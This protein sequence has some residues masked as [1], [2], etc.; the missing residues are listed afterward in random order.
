MEPLI[1]NDDGA[2]PVDEGAVVGV[3]AYCFPKRD[4]LALAIQ[5]GENFGKVKSRH[6]FE[7]LFDDLTRIEI[8]RY[9]SPVSCDASSN[10]PEKRK[11]LATNSRVANVSGVWK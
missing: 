2:M 1:R 8:S 6:A 7:F 3:I 9:V 4:P 11:R 5:A 10:R